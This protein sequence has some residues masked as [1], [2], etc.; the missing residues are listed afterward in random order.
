MGVLWHPPRVCAS[1]SG[2]LAVTGTVEGSGAQNSWIPPVPDPS[3]AVMAGKGSGVQVLEEGDIPAPEPPSMGL[4]QE[5]MWVRLQPQHSLAAAPQSSRIFLPSF[6]P[7]STTAE[8]QTTP[9]RAKLSTFPSPPSAELGPSQLT[10]LTGEGKKNLSK[11]LICL[12][13]DSSLLP[14][15][16]ASKAQSRESIMD[17][18]EGGES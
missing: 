9:F 7:T 14:S 13:C 16:P 15:F 8:P 17:T 10:F 11:Q 3:G 12:L 5:L 2:T 4:L 1:A 6:H 18:K